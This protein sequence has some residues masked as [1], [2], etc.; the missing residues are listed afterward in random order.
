MPIHEYKCDDCGDLFDHLFRSSEPV[1]ETRSCKLCG[2]TATKQLSTFSFAFGTPTM[3]RD[4]NSGVYAVDSKIDQVVGRD[5]QKRK[6]AMADRASVKDKVRRE[7]GQTILTRTK[8]GE[9][10]PTP[11]KTVTARN[12]LAVNVNKAF[13]DAKAGREGW[14]EGPSPT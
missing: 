13:K 4:G 9:Y 14:A 5:A 7:T 10:K 2:K 6:R 1:P 12:D 11:D 3:T 8:A